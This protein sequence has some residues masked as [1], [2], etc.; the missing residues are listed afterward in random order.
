MKLILHFLYLWGNNWNWRVCKVYLLRCSW[1]TNPNSSRSEGKTTGKCESTHTALGHCHV[2]RFCPGSTSP[3]MC[4]APH[5]SFA[6]GAIRRY[7]A[8]PSKTWWMKMKQRTRWTLLPMLMIYK[9]N[10]EMA[11][12][13][14]C[15]N[16]KEPRETPD[17]GGRREAHQHLL[18]LWSKGFHWWKPAWG[19]SPPTTIWS[20]CQPLFF[21]SQVKWERT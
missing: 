19:I 5:S 14:R 6:A 15:C 8:L 3:L 20:Y 12:R 2:S 21:W 16:S 10:C 7:S 11:S 4:A 13:R 1:K 17:T 9:L 18:L